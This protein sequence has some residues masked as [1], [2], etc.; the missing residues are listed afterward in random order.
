MANTSLTDARNDYFIVTPPVGDASETAITE[1]SSPSETVVAARP[2]PKMTAYAS[3]VAAAKISLKKKFEES[4]VKRD[5]GGKFA[6]KAGTKA[7][8]ST[9]AGPPKPSPQL[10]LSHEVMDAYL[11]SQNAESSSEADQA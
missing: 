1:E 7:T 8:T 4:K 5:S 9:S 11:L 3:L 6:K 10:Q 2:Q